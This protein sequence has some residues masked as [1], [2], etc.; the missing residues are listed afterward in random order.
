M[1]TTFS[2][3]VQNEHKN[4]WVMWKDNI[5]TDMKEPHYGVGYVWLTTRISGA[6]F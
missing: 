6:L 1:H 2:I 5:K 3:K 4:S